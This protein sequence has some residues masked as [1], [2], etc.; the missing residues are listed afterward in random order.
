MNHGRLLR[1]DPQDNV[2]VALEDLSEGHEA[3]MAGASGGAVLRVKQ[4]VPFAHKVALAPIA[5]GEA[6]LKYG[7]PIAFAS[8]DI[9][10][11]DWVHTHNAG[12]Y[13][14]AAREA[15]GR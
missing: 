8:T 12:S 3:E 5:R 10:P 11:G 1:I 2:A 14:A 15:A 6:I 9:Q 13:F 7:V 4:A